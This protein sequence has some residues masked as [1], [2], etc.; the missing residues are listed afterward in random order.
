MEYL[1]HIDV[2]KR[3]EYLEHH[4]I[5][6]QKWGVRRYQN[7]DGSLTAAGKRRYQ[8]DNFDK[9]KND[10]REGRMVH[11]DPHGNKRE[12]RYRDYN[13]I[14]NN[15]EL[16]K[17]IIDKL[18]SLY[19]D[20]VKAEIE[21]YKNP[22]D[23]KLWNKYTTAYNR[24]HAAQKDIAKEYYGKNYNTRMSKHSR[25]PEDLVRGLSWDLFRNK[26]PELEAELSKAENDLERSQLK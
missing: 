12:I 19:V 26:H 23:T 1:A 22:Y 2:S 18:D 25:T 10:S 14:K 5:L 15:K 16:E 8:K 4:G 3:E 11:L 24:I 17:H 6:G 7:P 13:N 9:L 21:S 20:C